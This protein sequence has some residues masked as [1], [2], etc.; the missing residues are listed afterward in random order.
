MRS[1]PFRGPRSRPSLR[2]LTRP[3]RRRSPTPR[4][5]LVATAALTAALA[6]CA[7]PDGAAERAADEALPPVELD[8]PEIEET[9][10]LKVLFTYNSTGY[11]IYRGEVMG[12]E[13][14]L[15]RAFAQDRG[16][17][18]QPVVVRDRTELFDL[19]D[20]GVGDVV[21]ARL[22]ESEIGES[23]NGA[24]ITQP[25]YETP[26]KLVQQIRGMDDPQLPEPTE[27]IIENHEGE[28]VG[29]SER[30]ELRELV[31]EAPRTRR[32]L[33][34]RLVTRPSQLAGRTVH[35]VRGSPYRSRLLEIE[36]TV[37]GEIRVVEI[38]G[39]EAVEELIAEIAT[40][41]P[42]LTVAP[43]NLADLQ[44]EYYANIK[45]MPV[46]GPPD[47]IVW[48]V[49]RNAAELQAALDE[50]L[51]THPKRIAR[52]YATYFEDRAAFR[53]RVA[54]AYLTTE[55]GRL[56]RYDELIREH[57]EEISWDWR[58]LASQAFQESRFQA[59]ARS[60]AGATGLLQIMPKTAREVGVRNLR[61]PAQNVAGAVRY[62][63]KLER[64]WARYLPG[65]PAAERLK[66]VLASYNAG[67]G[68]VQDARRLAEKHGD[69]PDSWDDV[70]YWLLRLS[71]QEIYND[72][73]V[74]FGFVRGL[75]PVTYVGLVLE[76]YE[77]YRDFVRAEGEGG[78]EAGTASTG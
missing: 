33:R 16:L 63:D 47:R 39:T 9:G 22:L 66:F 77:H 58:L 20:R 8:L 17:D 68:H 24:R 48:A 60:W 62:L 45:V 78:G 69:D 26:P 46:L 28:E 13:F 75:E 4:L 34:A 65:L 59:N 21:A 71:E 42:R 76:R 1:V 2:L 27:E 64:Y 5:A 35:L 41:P 25:L 38:E 51:A 15:L 40:G 19:L 57:A 50:W 11:F 7:G 14:R 12:F 10:V 61:D 31:E 43:G 36:D 54:S 18:L 67:F 44:E 30:E 3:D 29:E 52:E 32:E 49:R 55:T 72:P 23:A 53:E 73:V 74:E 70:A 37:T 56:S 6:G